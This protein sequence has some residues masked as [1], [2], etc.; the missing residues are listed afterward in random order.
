[1]TKATPLWMPTEAQR[2]ETLMA[3]FTDYVRDHSGFEGM[4]YRA[5]HQWSVASK[6]DFWRSIWHYCGVV[7][8]Q[9]PTQILDHEH[10]FPGAQWFAGAR[11]NFAENCL[12]GDSDQ[13]AIIELLENGRRCELTFAE[14][15]QRVASVRSF[16]VA[17]GVGKGDTVAGMMPNISDTVV[18][19]LATASVGAVWSSCSPD[20]GTEGALD[21]FGQIN[22]I[23]LFTCDG[24]Y[25]SGKRFSI[26]A[27]IR[28]IVDQLPSL[29]AVVVSDLLG[30]TDS[31]LEQGHA[32][33]DV[34]DAFPD[35]P[36]EYIQVDFHHPLYILYSSGTT[37]K[38]KCIVHSV[39]GTLLQH[40]KEHQLHSDLRAG[41]RLFFYTTCG[42]MMWNWL[43]SGLASNATVVIYDGAPIYPSASALF[44]RIM[45]ESVTAFGASAR[46][47]AALQQEEFEA[48]PEQVDTLRIMLSTGSPLAHESFEYVYRSIKSDFC[49]AS[50]CGGTDIVSSFVLGNPTLPVYAGQIQCAGLGMDVQVWDDT[51]ARLQHQ[52]GELV[53]ASPFPSAPIGFWNDVDGVR[54]H[55]AYFARFPGV[56]AHGDFA[57]ETP[58][59]GFIIY[60]RSDAVLNPGGVRIG[61]AEIYRQVEL[62]PEVLESVCVGQVVGDDVRVV[63]FVVMQPGQVL[64]DAIVTKI[65]TQIRR[66]AS[67]RHVPAVIQAMPDIPKTRSGKIAEI[68]VRKAIHGEPIGNTEALANPETLALFYRCLDTHSG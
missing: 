29:K 37:G 3:D 13:L 9:P 27:R 32:F 6:A 58:E 59:G 40:L 24:Y 44:E 55:D 60:G 7:S 11:L 8:A 53:C 25:Y 33:T 46:F 23:V 35:A 54:Y 49:L 38:P 4:D 39:G 16:L 12:K 26:G 50:I 10:A 19:M 51:G 65:K 15:R 64:T 68:P 1:M 14:L 31:D 45:S 62:I 48:R 41:D 22:P 56:W 63:L 57:E 36:L 34:L 17:Q 28:Q 67:P 52:K 42:W 18:A 43:V 20:F 47:I 61:T 2:A 5:L 21:R 30:E 66:G